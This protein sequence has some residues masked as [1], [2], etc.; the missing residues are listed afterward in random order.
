MEV[1]LYLAVAVA[2]TAVFVALMIGAAKAQRLVAAALFGAMALTTPISYPLSMISA[3]LISVPE[4][5]FIIFGMIALMV[6]LAH[7]AY[8]SN[9]KRVVP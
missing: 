7:R 9:I 1:V 4:G 5:L 6:W 8:R 3:G 2:F